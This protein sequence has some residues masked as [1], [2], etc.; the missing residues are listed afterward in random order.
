MLKGILVGNLGSDAEVKNQNGNQFVAFKVAD[1]RKFTDAS[2]KEHEDTVWVSCTLN[3]DGG[4]ITQFL[5]KG[6]KV[7]CIGRESFNV[8]SSP[9]DRCMKAGVQMFVESIELV[10]GTTDTVPRQLVSPSGEIVNVYK[11]YYIDPSIQEREHYTQ[12]MGVKGG[13]YN[14]SEVGYVAPVVE[15][16]TTVEDTFSDTQQ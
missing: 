1:S 5:K 11:A 6:A 8:Y 2:G 16:T 15:A 7:V 14:V 3:G 4:K 12:L 10:G 13:V 9:K